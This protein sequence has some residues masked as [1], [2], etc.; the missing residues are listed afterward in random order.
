MI[1]NRQ[2]KLT[3]GVVLL[4][5]IAFAIATASPVAAD[6]PGLSGVASPP[7]WAAHPGADTSAAVAGQATVGWK[8]VYVVG[9]VDSLGGSLTNSYIKEANGNA[10]E[11][12]AL[13]MTVVTF[14][15]PSNLWTDIVAAA[16]D[17]DVL[18]YAGHGMS[19]GG[20]P[21]TVGGLSLDS[22]R[23][24]SPDQI[25]GDLRMASNAI[26]IMSHVCFSSGG[27]TTDSGA[28]SSIEAQRRVAQYSDPFLDAG[29]VAYYSNWYGGFPAD[30]LA[31]LA[32][33]LTLGGA[34]ENYHDFD[35]DTVER[36]ADPGHT[37][38]AMWLDWD[39]WYNSIM[40]NYAFVGDE[41]L[42]PL[43]S[44]GPESVIG[45]GRES[46]QVRSE[47][48]AGTFAYEYTVTVST[49]L[50][51][52]WTAWL[53]SGVASWVTVAPGT[54]TSGDTLRL[55]FTVP[56]QPGTYETRLHIH[57]NDPRVTSPDAVVPI[58]LVV[59]LPAQYETA[60]PSVRG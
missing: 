12:R 26:V 56:A 7:A 53:D 44:V 16:A 18:V 57:T 10:E 6:G 2:Q 1:R 32:N 48:G 8:V 60:L 43:H 30:V 5:A 21:P 19:W 34:Y 39:Y 42:I 15:P 17:A 55:T 3:L 22:T 45:I 13:G 33:G 31:Y 38:Y 37:E 9:I 59:A 58:T 47:P 23:K 29:L 46:L 24:V 14:V 51:V 35:A 52:S 40:Y 36:Y 50:E 4:V 27:S 54:G 11:M 49:G 28:I 41:G 25:R 20:N